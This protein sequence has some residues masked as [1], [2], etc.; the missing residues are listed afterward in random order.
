MNYTEAM[1]AALQ[2]YNDT[3]KR[4]TQSQAGLIA[5]YEE[6]IR[7]MEELLLLKGIKLKK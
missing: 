3:L 7:L 2:D 1:L 5:H 6:K 4:L